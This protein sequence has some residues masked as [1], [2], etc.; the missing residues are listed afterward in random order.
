MK[1]ILQDELL[2]V[3]RMDPG[4]CSTTDDDASLPVTRM[5]PSSTKDDELLLPVTRMDP[6]FCSTVKQL[7]LLLAGREAGMGGPL[8]LFRSRVW[9]LLLLALRPGRVA[10]FEEDSPVQRPRPSTVLFVAGDG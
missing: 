6:G 3:T 2:P 1:G 10:V 9:M 5:D 8:G 7:F 4:F